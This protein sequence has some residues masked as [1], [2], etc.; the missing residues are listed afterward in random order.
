[1][2]LRRFLILAVV[3]VVLFFVISQPQGAANLVL[4]ILRLLEEAAQSVVTF[5][6]RLV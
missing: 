1:M 2:N 5:V 4:D 3:A 6:R